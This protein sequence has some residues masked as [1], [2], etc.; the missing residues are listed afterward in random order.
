M[1]APANDVR[2]PLAIKALPRTSQH[3]W[4]AEIAKSNV[5]GNFQGVRIAKNQGDH[6]NFPTQKENQLKRSSCLSFP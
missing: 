2:R 6:A 3:A 1:L 4:S 5:T